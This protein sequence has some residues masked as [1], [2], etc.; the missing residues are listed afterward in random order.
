MGNVVTSDEQFEEILGE[1]QK[2]EEMEKEKRERKKERERKKIV[3][4]KQGKISTKGLKKQ[5]IKG[6]KL[7][8]KENIDDY[9]EKS[10]DSGTS[11][12]ES[13]EDVYE[14]E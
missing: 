9:S 11:S 13:D 3:K 12:S 5:T 4:M 6:R 2:K 10:E 7:P 8:A 1:A 14:D